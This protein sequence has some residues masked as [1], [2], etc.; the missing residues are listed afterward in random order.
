MGAPRGEE[1]SSVWQ[2]LR[3]LPGSLMGLVQVVV[4]VLLKTVAEA[5]AVAA[6][7]KLLLCACR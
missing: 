4:R 3:P 6:A 7:E 2:A 5:I 1:I